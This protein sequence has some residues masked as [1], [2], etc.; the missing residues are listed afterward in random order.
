M[1][2]KAE[3]FRYEAQRAGMSRAKAKKRAA[4]EGAVLRGP[5]RAR[6]ATVAFEE[7]PS[8]IPPSRKSTRKSKHRQKGATP[9]TGRTLLAKST[10]QS[11]HEQKRP[12][13]RVAR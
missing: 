8:S 4:A 2:T 12:G 3:R 10:P 6:K 13:P 7:T 5:S 1:A 9:L 11:R